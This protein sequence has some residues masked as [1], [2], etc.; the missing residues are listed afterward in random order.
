[1]LP[2][3]PVFGR[4]LYCTSASDSPESSYLLTGRPENWPRGSRQFCG[5]GLPEIGRIG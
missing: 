3:A 5:A 2:S 4:A 1:M